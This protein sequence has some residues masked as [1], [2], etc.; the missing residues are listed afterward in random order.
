MVPDS[1][2]SSAD[3]HARNY[4]RGHCVVRPRIES[5]LETQPTQ[6]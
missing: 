1:N 4:T 6:L 2:H 3:D 5:D